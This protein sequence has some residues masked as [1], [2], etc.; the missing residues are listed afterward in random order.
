MLLDRS[1]VLH[2]VQGAQKRLCVREVSVS[3]LSSEN[4]CA[5]SEETKLSS[6]REHSDFLDL[7]TGTQPDV[8]KAKT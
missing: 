7:K 4:Q 5:S 3:K 8:T 6:L 1:S 2:T